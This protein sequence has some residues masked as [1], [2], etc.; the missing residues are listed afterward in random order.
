MNV[1]VLTMGV[2]ALLAG[3][4]SSCQTW[5]PTW[6]EVTGLRYNVAVMN[7]VPT[8]INAIDG[9]NPG[10][11]PPMS[12]PYYKVTPGKHNIELQALNPNPGWVSNKAL[13]TVAI[14]FEPCK[15]YYVNAQFVNL[16]DSDWQPVIDYVETIAGCRLPDAK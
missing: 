14:D 5:G 15:R 1:R 4:L 9:G 16:V 11:T 2:A 12:A 8:G 13:Q 7:R 3:G 10:P 6:S